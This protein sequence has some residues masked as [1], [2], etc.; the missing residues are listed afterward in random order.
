MKMRT[1][2]LK[3]G[4][5]EKALGFWET[6]LQ[7]KAHKRSPYWSELRCENINFGLLWIEDFQTEEDRSNF[8][9]VFELEDGELEAAKARALASGAMIVVD[10]ANHPDKMSY[11]LSDAFGN[12]FELTRF[13]G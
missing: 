4:E 1:A 3:V 12:E 5:M 10:I 8:V 2:Y 7:V 13:H 6:V 9:P 11:V